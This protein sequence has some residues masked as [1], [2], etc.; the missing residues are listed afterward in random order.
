MHA[1]L[2]FWKRESVKAT[3]IESKKTDIENGKKSSKN[4]F[5]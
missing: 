3:G 5:T 4:Q 2:V 1:D